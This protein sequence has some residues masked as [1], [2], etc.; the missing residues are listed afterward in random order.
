MD[1]KW[2]PVHAAARFGESKRV[3][4]GSDFRDC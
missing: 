4:D 2:L 3:A 1:Q